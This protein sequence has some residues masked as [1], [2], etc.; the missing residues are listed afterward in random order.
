MYFANVASTLDGRS[1]YLSRKALGEELAR[2]ETVPMDDN[3]IVVP[4]PDTSKAAADAM[5]YNLKVPSVEGLI[6]NRYSGRPSS[7]APATASARPK[8]STRRSAKCWRARRVL[9]VED[10]IVR[11]TTMKVLLQRIRQVGR[12]S[13]IHVRVACPPII[14]PCFY[15]IDMSTVSELFAPQFMQA[16]P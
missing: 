8:P 5:A 6:R 15:G 9:L 4:V 14:S 10:S 13:E 7:K 11:S 1:V 16:A 12:P 3:T 2:L